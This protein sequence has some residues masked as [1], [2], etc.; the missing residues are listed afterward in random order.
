[1][2]VLKAYLVQA[3]V[4]A[5]Q[6]SGMEKAEILDLA[7]KKSGSWECRRLLACA[8]L[9]Q[10]GQPLWHCV[11]AAFRHPTVFATVP[12]LHKELVL[13]VHPDKNPGDAA[14]TPAFQFLQQAF[15]EMRRM[16]QLQ[17]AAKTV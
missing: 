11:M 9:Q 14:A 2:Q 15:A 17:Q 6:M 5:V 16:M 10:A 13:L 3:G 8:A 1:M 12:Q 7:L 4:T